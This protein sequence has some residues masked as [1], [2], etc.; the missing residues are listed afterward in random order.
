MGGER[1]ARVCV[2]VCVCGRP[3]YL[4]CTMSGPLAA[5]AR[6]S[7][8]TSAISCSSGSVESGVLWSGQDV[9]Q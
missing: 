8:S 3:A 5:A 1:W 7:A 2:C 9:N 4:Q 6:L